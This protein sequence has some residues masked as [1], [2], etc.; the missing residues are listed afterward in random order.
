MNE[1]TPVL[2]NNIATQTDAVTFELEERI[3]KI[4]RQLKAYR[5]THPNFAKVWIY[6]L[7]EKVK[8]LELMMDHCDKISQS[9]LSNTPDLD[10]YLLASLSS[11]L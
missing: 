8:N 2:T 1:E 10:P 3:D 7:R 11:I 9:D 5:D 6:Y 4:R